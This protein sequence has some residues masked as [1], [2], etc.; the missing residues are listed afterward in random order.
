MPRR[1]KDPDQRTRRNKAST[2]ALLESE[3]AEIARPIPELP[4]A[5]FPRS[6]V[7]AMTS[8][9][10]AMIWRSPM[11]LNW[12]EADMGGLYVLA[13]LRNEFF[14]NPRVTFASEIRQQE[15]RF[16]L[17]PLDRRRLEWRIGV[18]QIDAKPPQPPRPE[19]EKRDTREI[20]RALE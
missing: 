20:L 9:W 16:G 15:A 18:P 7:H 12:L 6:E 19:R 1:L 17:S 5:L 14:M 8:E 4:K 10:W 3:S 2:A 13:V 11:A